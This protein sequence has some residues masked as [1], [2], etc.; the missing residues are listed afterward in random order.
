[1]YDISLRGVS[2][3]IEFQ[4]IIGLIFSKLFR[5]FRLFEPVADVS[6]ENFDIPAGKDMLPDRG[7]DFQ[8]HHGFFHT[9]PKLI[10]LAI[11]ISQVQIGHD[12]AELGE[13]DL[14]AMIVISIDDFFL[15]F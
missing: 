8:L 2:P 3:L 11:S 5:L 9:F 4:G 12:L 15:M 1:M 14:V 13:H 10:P 7:F 6:C